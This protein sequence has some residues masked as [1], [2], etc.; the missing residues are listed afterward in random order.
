MQLCGK[1]YHQIIL[2]VLEYNFRVICVYFRFCGKVRLFSDLRFVFAIYGLQFLCD[3]DMVLM[4]S[5]LL[6]G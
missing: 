5:L 4:R 2:N 3:I 1:V 6:G